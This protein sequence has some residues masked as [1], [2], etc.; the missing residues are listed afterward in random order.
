MQVTATCNVSNHPCSWPQQSRH[1]A[2]C[3]HCHY[4]DGQH[5]TQGDDTFLNELS[6]YCFSEDHVYSNNVRLVHRCL[7]V[8]CGNISREWSLITPQCT[9][10]LCHDAGR[11]LPLLNRRNEVVLGAEWTAGVPQWHDWEWNLGR[12]AAVSTIRVSKH[13]LIWEILSII[14]SP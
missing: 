14:H 7:T 12:P 2:Q 13:C 10:L 4:T 3:R 6:S 1:T 9:V 8:Y 11:D 5:C